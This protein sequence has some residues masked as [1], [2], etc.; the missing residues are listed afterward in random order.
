M[1]NRPVQP[2]KVENYLDRASKLYVKTDEPYSDSTPLPQK[3]WSVIDR[4][5]GPSVADVL[6]KK[7]HQAVIDHV[8]A[9]GRR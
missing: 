4:E 6:A 1:S 2:V 7:L 5:F 3:L 8:T 9:N